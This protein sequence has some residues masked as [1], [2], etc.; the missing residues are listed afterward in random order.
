MTIQKTQSKK[1]SLNAAKLFI[2]SA[3]LTSLFG[4]WNLFSKDENNTMSK[5]DSE[6][7]D[8]PEEQLL[9]APL[10]TLAPSILDQ[11][12][13]SQTSQD[14]AQ[15]TPPPAEPTPEPVI[16]RVVIGNSGSSS[17]NSSTRT[18]SSR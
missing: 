5:L 15:I 13:S 7:T 18:S 16:E 10:P 4:L 1:K 8:S 12:A 9:N 14:I 17:G 2:A 6:P 11:G 3:S